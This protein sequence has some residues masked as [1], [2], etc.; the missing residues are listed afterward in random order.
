MNT[1]WKISWP[2]ATRSIFE[3]GYPHA[4]H[5]VTNTHVAAHPTEVRLPSNATILQE[6]KKMGLQSNRLCLDAL[7]PVVAGHAFL[8]HRRRHAPRG[9]L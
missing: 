6:D 4:Y 1:G 9:V 2:I 7:A 8:F 3:M 5:R